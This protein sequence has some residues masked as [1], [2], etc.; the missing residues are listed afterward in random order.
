MSLKG[1]CQQVCWLLV[2]LSGSVAA[3]SDNSVEA[4][5]EELR[6]LKSD[7]EDRM[8]EL[9]RRIERAERTAGAVEPRRGGSA[10]S[11][12]SFN[13]AISLILDGQYAAYSNDTELRDVPGFQQGG[14]AGGFDEG[15]ALNEGEL[16]LEAN[17]D[18]KFFASSTVA[19]ESEGGETHVELEEAYLQTLA[20]P[21]GMTLKAGKFFSGIGYLNEIHP[22]ATPFVDDPLPY[23]VMLGGRLSDTG[24]QFV[25]T[26]ATLL[27]MQFGGEL[28]S[29][30][31][32]PASGRAHDGAGTWS[33]FARFGGDFNISNSWLASLSYLS[34]D[35][36]ERGSGG[37]AEETGIDPLFTGDSDTWIGSF[38]WKWAYRGNPRS[39]S[40]RLTAEYFSRS[41]E[42]DLSFGNSAGAYDGDQTGY[43][44]EGVYQFRPQWRVGLRYDRLDPDNTVTGLGQ[45]VILGQNSHKP[46]RTSAMID[47]RNSEFSKIRLQYSRDESSSDS[48]DQLILQYI[49]SMGAHGGH[50]F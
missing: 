49:M 14:E 45:P 19:F 40:F 27:Y 31:G 1:L 4:L 18:D 44:I 5:R 17:I 25:W 50:S 39:R 24:I 37:T 20:L 32:F 48:D 15:F 10:V 11:D 7:Y 21:A 29:G 3:A 16:V 34:A 35:A 8:A 30:S 12:K 42:G 38:V 26:P 47:F 36:I 13:P 43:Y 6:K 28:L 22:H 46:E 23:R 41:E 2:L 9:E 33:A